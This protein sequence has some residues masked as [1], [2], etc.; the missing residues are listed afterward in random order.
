MADQQPPGEMRAEAQK[1][2][3]AYGFEIAAMLALFLIFRNKVAIEH[4]IWQL[5]EGRR[6]SS[7][8]RRQEDQFLAAR[9]SLYDNIRDIERERWGEGWNLT[10]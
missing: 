5:T 8:A 3:I 9:P 4:R 2:A 7:P 1:I 6:Q 10:P